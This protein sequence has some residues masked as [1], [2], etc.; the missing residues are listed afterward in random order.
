[1]KRSLETCVVVCGALFIVEYG[2]EFTVDPDSSLAH[3]VGVMSAQNGEVEEPV[4]P[5]PE[6]NVQTI[7]IEF[8]N[9]NE[10]ITAAIEDEKDFEKARELLDRSL[11]RTRRWNE[12]E[13]AFF[14][15]R[16]ANLGQLLE[17]NDL[18][19]EHLKKIL[20]YREYV[21]YFVEEETLWL[22]NTIYVSTYQDYETAL[23]YIQEWLDLT[24]DWNEGSKHYHYIGGVHAL[25]GDFS[26][27]AEWLNRAIDKANEEE[28]EVPESW[29]VQLF[30]AYVQLSEENEDSPAE[31]DEYLQKALELAKFLVYNYRKRVENWKILSSVFA[32]ISTVSDDPE[33]Q[34]NASWAYTMESAFHMG[35]LSKELEFKR[36]AAGMLSA[37]AYSRAA[38]VYKEG[39]DLEII[40]RNFEN[41]NK[42]AQALY[43]STDIEKAAEAYE[44]AVSFKD[45]AAVLHSL[46]SLYQMMENFSKCITFADRALN[47]TAG[48]LK[49]PEQVKFLK[50]VC[51]FYNDD[52][53]GSEETMEEIRAEISSDTESD[54]LQSLRESAGQYIEL[55]DSERER[56]KWKEYVEDQWRQYNAEKSGG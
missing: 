16:Y 56:I 22:I 36:V 12:R 55:V 47:A 50:G 32:K 9:Q 18:M 28:S 29:W 14:H 30:Q 11:E 39:F 19:L 41:L 35:L 54:R 4:D 33:V 27:N 45:D 24:N 42:Y 23:E 1:M 43:L 44:E 8:F 51:Q 26:K 46:A 13:L 20:E 6:R 15:R 21:K 53:K 31:R 40:E 34:V 25:T 2:V 17:D 52:L 49:Q 10:K 5:R 48:E 3:L 37:E 38:W 7:G